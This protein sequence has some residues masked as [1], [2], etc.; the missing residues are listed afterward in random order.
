VIVTVSLHTILRKQT[1]E[2]LLDRLEM[3]LPEGASVGDVLRGLDI[4]LD[5][6]AIILVVDHRVVDTS[7]RLADG[8]QLDI[9]PA[10][11]GG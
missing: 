11:S 4:T 10:I 6:G 8:D 3:N 2:G 9:I 1:P 5:P 7:V